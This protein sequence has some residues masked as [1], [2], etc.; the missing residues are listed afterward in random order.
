MSTHDVDDDGVNH[1]QLFGQRNAASF[2]VQTDFEC[3]PQSEAVWYVEC[4]LAVVL[5]FLPVLGL[6]LGT[7]ALPAM[8]S[9][10]KVCCEKASAFS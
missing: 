3:H 6:I 5:Y 7:W 2:A 9:F 8:L 4:V 10:S 1:G